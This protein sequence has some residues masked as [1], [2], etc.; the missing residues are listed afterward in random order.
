MKCLLLFSCRLG[1]E[2]C[3]L[4]I[5]EVNG[6]GVIVQDDTE[7]FMWIYHGK[8]WICPLTALIWQINNNTDQ[9]QTDQGMSVLASGTVRSADIKMVTALENRY[10]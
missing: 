3:P 7:P 4:S 5:Q 6:S 1:T 8:F 9:L 2:R 10:S